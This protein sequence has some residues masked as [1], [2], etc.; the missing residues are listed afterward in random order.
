MGPR[1]RRR[2]KSVH[3]RKIASSVPRPHAGRTPVAAL[4]RMRQRRFSFRSL[5]GR[6]VS[7]PPVTLTLAFKIKYW[8]FYACSTNRR[9]VL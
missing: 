9:K 1:S 6:T 4:G 7:S 8:S 2:E 5:L 3:N